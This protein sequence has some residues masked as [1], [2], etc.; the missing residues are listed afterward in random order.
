MFATTLRPRMLAALLGAAPLLASCA[1][2]ASELAWEFTRIDAAYTYLEAAVREG[3]CDGPLRSTDIAPRSQSLDAQSLGPGSYGLE[4]LA[5]DETCA[6]VA[7]GCTEV[8]LPREGAVR[9]EL[10]TR[11]EPENC[12][13][14][15]RRTRCMPSADPDAGTLDAGPID[16]TAPDAAGDSSIPVECTAPADCPCGGDTCE[17]GRCIPASPATRVTTNSNTS[18]VEADGTLFCWGHAAWGQL[19]TGSYMDAGSPQRVEGSGWSQTQ[20]GPVQ[21]CAL[22]D[23]RIHCA[24]ANADGQLGVPR[25]GSGDSRARF[26]AHEDG[27]RSDAQFA[28][29]RATCFALT[30]GQLWAWGD[31]LT[32]AL[33]RDGVQDR[34]FA[35]TEF[36]NPVDVSMD[37]YS[38]YV[39]DGAQL[40]AWGGNG[41]YLGIGTSSEADV[42]TPT[43]LRGN[44]WVDVAAGF[45]HGCGRHADGRISCW[46]LGTDS[47]QTEPWLPCASKEGAVGQG[48]ASATS[49]TVVAGFDAV[50]LSAG[51]STCGIDGEGT[52]RCFG[53]NRFG[54]IGNGN[55]APV[56]TPTIVDGEW[57]AVA[58]AEFHTCGI[59]RGGQVLCWGTNRDGLLG[60]GTVDPDRQALMPERVCLP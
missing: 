22:R 27:S 46:G 14:D 33:G 12:D 21:T 10:Q 15:C 17:G 52:L 7:S 45:R 20:A 48:N 1:P 43:S 35:V 60:L 50:Q 57:L 24:G 40:F 28:C 47:V 56:H 18:C 4:L 3:G 34:P 55:T 37:H 23:G 11:A 49:P 36:D 44:D 58:T 16:P 42:T 38:A 41:S 32:D 31:V 30:D 54:E 19:G 25:T 5:R 6:I 26:T 53:P 13:A 51:C 8:T 2:D 59:R 39:L 9:V 29:S